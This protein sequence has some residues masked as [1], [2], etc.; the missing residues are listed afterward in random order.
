MYYAIRY[1]GNVEVVGPFA[2]WQAACLNLFGIIDKA[3]EVKYL[4]DKE[5]WIKKGNG[6]WVTNQLNAREGWFSPMIVSGHDKAI[7]EAGALGPNELSKILLD[8]HERMLAAPDREAGKLIYDEAIPYLRYAPVVV[9]QRLAEA[10]E[11]RHPS[12]TVP[13]VHD[14]YVAQILTVIESSL[15]SESLCRFWCGVHV[16]LEAIDRVK[17]VE[18][19]YKLKWAE[20][21]RAEFKADQPQMTEAELNEAMCIASYQ[22]VPT[23]RA[24]YKQQI[25]RILETGISL[26]DLA[27]KINR[28]RRWLLTIL[29]DDY[30]EKLDVK[31][32]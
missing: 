10:F 23:S 4:T 25:L 15:I 22:H 11:I 32:H 21:R 3:M 16:M 26:D 19:D 9:A 2:S 8:I 13:T 31:S 14:A 28:S 17:D 29:G 5:Y 24:E 1:G 6:T 18:A 20:L 7:T 30:K 12:A 27:K